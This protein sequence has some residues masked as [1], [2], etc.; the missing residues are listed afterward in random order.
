MSS[1]GT[2]QSIDRVNQVANV[3]IDPGTTPTPCRYFGDPPPP[4]SRVSVDNPVPGTWVCRGP[5]VD[6]RL[7][8]HDDFLAADSGTGYGDTNW[9]FFTVAGGSAGQAGL[10]GT[11]GSVFIN[12]SATAG[13]YALLYK[14]TGAL[15]IPAAPGA[16]WLSGS[17]ATQD[18]GGVVGDIYYVLGFYD[19]GNIFTSNGNGVNIYGF[20]SATALRNSLAAATHDVT[21]P[22]A[23]VGGQT[24][25][26]LDLV[27]T[28]TFSAA[29]YNGNGPFVNTTG[30]PTAA[31]LT[32][33]FGVDP[34]TNHVAQMDADWVHLE[35]VASVMDPTRPPF[36]TGH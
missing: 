24:F 30:I 3:F 19:T 13:Q 32:V 21:M 11:A 2:V 6:S 27:S 14:D 12:T 31:A 7:I 17:V 26:T 18:I 36:V 29:W 4:L 8:L 25:F 33:E 9:N 1:L 35:R 16:L 15:T 28:A 10:A 5:Q 23:V 22:Q 34:L 20:A